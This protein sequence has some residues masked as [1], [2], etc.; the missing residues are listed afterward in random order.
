MLLVELFTSLKQILVRQ[1]TARNQNQMIKGGSSFAANSLVEK[2]VEHILVEFN[3]PK[4]PRELQ[5]KTN[6]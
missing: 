5:P 1:V 6:M 2:I 4:L 3:R